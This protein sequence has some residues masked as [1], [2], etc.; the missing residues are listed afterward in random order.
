G[1]LG[2]MLAVAAAPW[3]LN[4]HLLDPSAAAPAA[5]LCSRFVQGDFRDKQTVR[6]LGADC[7]L[8]TIEIEQVNVDALEEMEAGGKIVHPCSAALRIIQDKGLQKNF[9]REQGLPTADYRF[10][11]GPEALRAA[12]VTFPCVQKMRT[13][14]YDGRG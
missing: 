9:F 5:H 1:Q 4:L 7:D 12:G 8:L 6:G 2:K 10:F 11:D 3:D 14:G 13:E